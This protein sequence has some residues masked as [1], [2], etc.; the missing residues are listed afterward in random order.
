MMLLLLVLVLMGLSAISY[1][2]GADSRDGRDWTPVPAQVSTA[3]L[4]PDVSELRDI[5]GPEPVPPAPSWWPILAWFGG[6]LAGLTIF[7]A[8]YTAATHKDQ[9]A[10]LDVSGRITDSCSAC[11]RVYRDKA[12]GTAARCTP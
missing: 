11:H 1:R 12:G 4:N 5:T 3:I 8:A 10:M 6:S 9:D 2:W 7:L